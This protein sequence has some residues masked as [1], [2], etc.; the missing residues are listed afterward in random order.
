[1]ARNR[2]TASILATLRYERDRLGD[3]TR[4]LGQAD[5]R[6]GLIAAEETSRLRRKGDRRAFLIG[7]FILD[8]ADDP[9]FG[10]ILDGLERTLEKRGDRELFGLDG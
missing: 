5:A 10:T 8:H 7:N 3:V 9:L 1:M 2:T 4:R 6:A